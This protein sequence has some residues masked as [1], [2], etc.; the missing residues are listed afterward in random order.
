M[1]GLAPQRQRSSSGRRAG[2]RRAD[3]PGTHGSPT[4]KRFRHLSDRETDTDPGKT[5][6]T[7]GSLNDGDDGDEEEDD[8]DDDNDDDNFDVEGIVAEKWDPRSSRM[9][10][11]VHWKGFEEKDYT[12]EPKKHFHAPDTLLDWE[13]LKQATPAHQ[14]FDWRAW[15]RRFGDGHENR[16]DENSDHESDGEPFRRSR[17][18]SAS[19]RTSDGSSAASGVDHSKDNRDKQ[20]TISK[21]PRPDPDPAITIVPQITD[22]ENL[23]EPSNCPTPSQCSYTRVLDREKLTSSAINY[24][25]SSPSAVQY[26]ESSRPEL[27]P[28]GADHKSSSIS[29]I[30]HK[31][32]SDLTISSSASYDVHDMRA[33]EPEEFLCTISV[34]GE[35]S[36][37][38]GYSYLVGLS[39]KFR[40]HLRNI[41]IHNFEIKRFIGFEYLEKAFIQESGL[42]SECAF[43]KTN[44]KLNDTFITRLS[45]LQGAAVV[46]E[47]TF[48]MIFAPSHSHKFHHIFNAQ[49]SSSCEL[50]L[51]VY[52]PLDLDFPEVSSHIPSKEPEFPGRFILESADCDLNLQSLESNQHQAAQIA[53]LPSACAS[54][55]GLDVACSFEAYRRKISDSLRPLPDDK[56]L[57]QP[58]D[59]LAQK[60]IGKLYTTSSFYLFLMH[61]SLVQN[62]H[63]IPNLALLRTLKY[64]TFL[65]FGPELELGSSSINWNIRPIF[66]SGGVL[67]LTLELVLHQ[68]TKV[69]EILERVV[70]HL[71]NTFL[72]SFT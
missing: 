44:N 38:Q 63:L 26:E 34:Y 31:N 39:V 11:L 47:N 43:V 14:R 70:C 53:L 8:D 58:Y 50:S 33:S 51:V 3:E 68:A 30:V 60:T 72:S 15:D 28:S 9:L 7:G 1:T 64:R 61:T 35:G 12:W 62:L 23:K 4:E 65:T 21:N 45:E 29:T 52:P 2:A 40:R 16:E 69:L 54:R 22:I 41:G 66:R 42:P 36:N 46:L 19:Q 55:Y 10:Y 6:G 59:V 37:L 56:I 18:D 24:R 27:V 13:A 57:L 71:T 48:T 25:A 5:V 49:A 67:L 17:D 20:T 32:E